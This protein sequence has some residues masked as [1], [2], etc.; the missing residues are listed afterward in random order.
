MNGIGLSN[1]PNQR[2]R[3]VSRKGARLTVL[4]VGE[5]GLGKATLVNALFSAALVNRRAQ[6]TDRTVNID[7]VRADVV[8]RGFGMRLAVVDTPVQPPLI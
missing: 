8:E 4:V 2:H 5:A 7:V 1:L 6:P 3:L